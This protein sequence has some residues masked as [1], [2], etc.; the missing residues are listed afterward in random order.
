MQNI[1]NK[2][3]ADQQQLFIDDFATVLFPWGMPTAVARIFGFLMLQEAPIGLDDIC[4]HLQISKSTASVSTR[5]LERTGI[6]KRHS[7]RGTKKV[8]YSVNA[9]HTLVMQDKLAMLSRLADLLLNNSSIANGEVA[10]T[11]FNDM[12]HFC[13]RLRT[14]MEAVAGE[15]NME[16]NTVTLPD[17]IGE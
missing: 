15:V 3:L 17:R 5:E 8:L 14:V 11:R 1:S 2:N 7:I 10:K 13:L 9:G 16:W 4:Q 6:V 12:A